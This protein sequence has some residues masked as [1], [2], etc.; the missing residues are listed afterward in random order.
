MQARG[1]PCGLHYSNCDELCDLHLL[2]CVVAERFGRWSTLGADCGNVQC[3]LKTLGALCLAP[4]GQ[5]L[6]GL[7][8]HA[9]RYIYD[10]MSLY[11]GTCKHR[12]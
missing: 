6:S 11:G 3:V 12:G 8:A 7:L 5:M 1:F 2:S 10:A 9:K 4:E